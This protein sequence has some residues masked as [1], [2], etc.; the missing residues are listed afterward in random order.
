MPE[1]S[2]RIKNLPP[3]VFAVIGEKVREMQLQGIDIIRMD[4]GSPDLEKHV[5]SRRD[6]KQ[7]YSQ[8]AISDMQTSIVAMN[9]PYLAD[10]TLPELHFS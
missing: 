6:R 5:R 9:D 4:I 1:V 8:R 10:V 7:A 2:D 3:Y